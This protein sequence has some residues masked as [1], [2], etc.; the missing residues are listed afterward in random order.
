MQDI[1]G[2]FS[3][4]LFG[5]PTRIATSKSCKKGGNSLSKAITPNQMFHITDSI[6]FELTD[7]ESLNVFIGYKEITWS[8]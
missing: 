8:E 7:R 5:K 1:L 4:Y 6:D 3:E 2:A